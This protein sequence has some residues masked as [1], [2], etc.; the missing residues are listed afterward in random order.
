MAAQSPHLLEVRGANVVTNG[1]FSGGTSGSGPNGWSLFSSG[2]ALDWDVTSGFNFYRPSGSNQGVIEQGTGLSI[3]AGAPVEAT[4]TLG[5]TD[6]VTKRVTV[7]LRSAGW[8]DLA[9]CNFYL[10]ASQSPASYTMRTHTTLSWSNATIDFYAADVNAGSST[11]AYQLD[12]VV[13]TYRPGSSSAATECVDPNAPT[14]GGTTSSNLITNGAFSDGTNNWSLYGSMESRINNGVLEYYRTTGSTAPYVAQTFGSVG[15]S[16]RLAAVFEMGNTSSSRQRVMVSL[17]EADAS[18]F[19]SCV[20]YLAAGTPRRA[21]AITTA[22]PVSWSNAAFTVVPNNGGTESSHGWLQLD[23]VSVNKITTSIAGTGCYE[24]GSFTVDE[25][26]APA[27]VPAPAALLVKTR[28]EVPTAPTSTTSRPGLP[29]LSAERSHGGG[30]RNARWR[31]SCSRTAR[32]RRHLDGE[33]CPGQARER[34]RRV[35]QE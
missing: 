17:Q 7:I 11:G 26:S 34:F 14:S 22:A 21:Y 15:A 5:N 4:F 32:A 28:P 20:F 16:Q 29:L 9:I 12:D 24:P 13:L 25:E 30:E 33:H 8:D 27:P 1:D 31:Q 2:T 10:P 19:I 3:P 35:L 6:T 18:T 23:T